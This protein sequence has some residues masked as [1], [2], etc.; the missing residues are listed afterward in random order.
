MY[1]TSRNQA[2]WRLGTL[3]RMSAISSARFWVHSATLANVGVAASGR[4]ERT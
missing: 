2:R 4:G 1:M 3:T